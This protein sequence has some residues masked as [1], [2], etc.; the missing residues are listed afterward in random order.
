M[1]DEALR[2]RPNAHIGSVIRMK[3]MP[4][5]ISPEKVAHIIIKSRAFESEARPWDDTQ[6]RDVQMS[7][8]NALSILEDRGSDD[9]RDEIA[10][11]IAGL[12]DDE[13][14]ALV[15]LTWVGRG[16]YEPEE[17]E[18]AVATATREKVNKTEEY[19]L[20]MPLLPDYLEEGLEALGYAIEDV[21]GGIL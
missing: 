20:G 9:T 19:L 18:R 5:D 7:E 6:G 3:G 12:N 15:A 17:W 16:S 14:I 13:Q 11:F 4:M 2:S 21:E 1:K 10:A 8:D